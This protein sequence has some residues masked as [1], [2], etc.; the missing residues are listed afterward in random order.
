MKSWNNLCDLYNYITNIIQF[1]V[2][3]NGLQ[4]ILYCCNTV[5]TCWNNVT[6]N[7]DNIWWNVLTLLQSTMRNLHILDKKPQKIGDNYDKIPV[8]VKYWY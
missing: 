1:F 4:Y 3:Q 8:H 7:A 6:N 5:K 2:E